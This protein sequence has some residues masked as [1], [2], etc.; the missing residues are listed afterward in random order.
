MALFG[1]VAFTAPP[2]KKYISLWRL[3]YP[4]IIPSVIILGNQY[5]Y[6]KAVTCF[7]VSL[8]ISDHRPNIRVY[9]DVIIRVCVA[10]QSSVNFETFRIFLRFSYS[11][12]CVPMKRKKESS[13]NIVCSTWSMM[14]MMDVVF[15]FFS[16]T[17]TKFL[18]SEV[19]ALIRSEVDEIC[20]QII[21][22]EDL[23][24]QPSPQPAIPPPSQTNNRLVTR[25]K[26]QSLSS[27]FSLYLSLSS[28]LRFIQI[29]V[30]HFPLWF[31]RCQRISS[32]V[33]FTSN[34]HSRVCC[35]L[36]SLCISRPLLPFITKRFAN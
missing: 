1:L 34:L 19:I 36:C 2:I 14:M 4:N 27:S 12:V 13:Q 7:R 20:L 11:S 30:S 25:C 18:C 3:T 6:T 8:R 9:I 29:H 28:S 22:F 23:S 16:V 26:F 35:V 32:L 24:S 15:F 21:N 17:G 33:N 5:S 31:I 10:F